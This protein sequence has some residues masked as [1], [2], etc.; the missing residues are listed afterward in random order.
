[1]E[2]NRTMTRV[3]GL[4]FALL[5]LCL[6]GLSTGCFSD[7]GGPA[8]SAPAGRAGEPR[9]CLTP[10]DSKRMAD[11]VLQLVNLERAAAD[12][13]LSPVVRSDTLAKIAGDYAC[14]MID[15]KFFSHHDPI[16][17]R[18]LAERAVAGKYAFYAVGENLA[19]VPE[20][21]AEVMKVW[22]QSPAHRDIILDPKWVEMGAAVRDGGEYSTYW[23]QLFG[24]P[25]PR[26]SPH[27]DI[28]D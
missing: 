27:G 3:R 2:R 26:S 11:Q 8:Q 24:H 14:R 28:D 19:A 1:M 4:S 5:S 18:G 6:S 12:R 16:T 22:M 17:G 23:V 20:T 15:Q 10:E 21:A 9:A 13:N 25:A 7:A